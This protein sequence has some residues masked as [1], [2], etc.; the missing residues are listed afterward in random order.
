MVLRSNVEVVPVGPRKDYSG[1]SK[2]YLRC[3][4][5]PELEF[6]PRGEQ[7]GKEWGKGLSPRK[8]EEARFAS[9]VPLFRSP[10]LMGEYGC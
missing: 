4:K 7:C 8:G 1:I 5:R 6:A 9:E 10:E 3:K 2:V